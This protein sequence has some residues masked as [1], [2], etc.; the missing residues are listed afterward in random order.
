MANLTLEIALVF[1]LII[2]A[3]F[4]ALA[5]VALL[6]VSRHKVRLIVEKKMPG[7]IHVKLLKDDPQ[8]ML[9]TLLIGNNLASFGA[10]T[11]VTSISIDLFHN[12]ALGIAIGITTFTILIFGELT[13]KVIGASNSELFSRLVAP[14]LWYM[15][16][17][18]YPVIFIVDIFLNK[19]IKITGAKSKYNVTE[20]E[21][22]SMVS[23]AKEEGSIREIEKNLIHNIFKFDEMSVTEIMTPKKDVV[24][25]ESDEKTKNAIK[26]ILK[27]KYSRIPVYEEDTDNIVGIIYLKD[28]IKYSSSKRASLKKL[29]RDPYFIPETKKISDLLRYFQKRKEQMAII[30]NEHGS[31]I[32]I[33]TLEDVIEQIVGEITDENEKTTYNIIKEKNNW[34]VKGKTEIKE[35]N[36]AIGMNL[37][38]ENYDTIAGFVLEQAGKIPKK[39]DKIVYKKFR[40][41][42]QNIEDNRIVSVKIE[43]LKEDAKK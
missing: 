17:A 11:L 25:I 42:V 18:I 40:I 13:P 32:G 26:L 30:L 3:A 34:I 33:V 5:E 19:L 10:S 43:K 21:I 31:F 27:S 35:I 7:A 4:F 36:E 41:I 29:L 38:G 23:M 6:S 12:Y 20:E 28:L 14:P 9:T 37:K 39:N 16:I 22:S 1:I 24:M 15:S 8:R 2:C